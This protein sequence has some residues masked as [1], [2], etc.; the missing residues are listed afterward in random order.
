MWSSDEKRISFNLPSSPSRLQKWQRFLR[1]CNLGRLRHFRICPLLLWE[2]TPIEDDSCHL[3]GVHVLWL[4]RW[5]EQLKKSYQQRFCVKRL[6]SFFLCQ[7][8]ASAGFLVSFMW[9]ISFTILHASLS[10]ICS[11][12]RLLGVNTQFKRNTFWPIQETFGSK[13]NSSSAEL[14]PKTLLHVFLNLLFIFQVGA[15]EYC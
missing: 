13:R 5:N 14:T 9:E 1:R 3:K 8:K 11:S 10:C 12:R 4:C 2:S 7:K 6:F 15:L